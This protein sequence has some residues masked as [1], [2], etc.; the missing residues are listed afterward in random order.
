MKVDNKKMYKNKIK[1]KTTKN[2]NFI[3]FK[4]KKN[5]IKV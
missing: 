2:V 3:P 4:K 5:K 1:L